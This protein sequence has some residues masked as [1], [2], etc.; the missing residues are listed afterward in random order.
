MSTIARKVL[1]RSTR[2][3]KAIS[4]GRM[5]PGLMRADVLRR[6]GFYGALCGLIVS[7]L[8]YCGSTGRVFAAGP[9]RVGLPW[10]WSHEHLLFSQTD[11]PKVQAI[12]QKDPRAFH[13]WLRRK[14]AAYGVS[15]SSESFAQSDGALF[16]SPSPEANLDPQ[17][18]SGTVKTT[19]KRDWGVSLGA[20][21]FTAVNG[22][23]TPLYPAKYTFNIN[24]VPS[25]IN[26]YAVFPTG[27]QG[28]TS[29]SIVTPNGQAS[30]VAYN[31]LYSTQTGTGT[32]GG[33]G[34]P[35]EN[36][37]PVVYWA[38][39][40]AACPTTASSDPIL[41]SPVISQDGTKVAWV[42]T[43][44]KVQIVA[45]GVGFTLSGPAEGALTPACIGP[46][47]SGGDNATLQTLTLGNATHTP[48]SGVS[49]SEIFVDYSTDSAYVGDDDGYLHKISPFFTASGALQEVTTSGWQASHAYNVGNLIVDTNGFIEKCT[50]AGTSGSVTPGWSN[51]W[52]SA[53]ND[54]TAVWTNIGSGGGWPVYVTGSSGH[55]DSSKLNG[56]VFDS[57]SKNVF[58]GGQ[59]GSLYY[60][61]DPPSSTVV[62]SC[63][64][65]Q[66]LYPCLGLPAAISGITA[67]AGSQTDCYHASPGPTCM[68]M[69]NQQGFTDPV[70]VDS[71]HKLVLAQFA[72]ADG[73]NAKVEQTNTSLGVYHS[74]TLTSTTNS[75]TAYH[76]GAFD[77]T[78]YS[79]P[80]SGYYYVCAPA[81]DGIETDLYRVSFTNTAGTVALGSKNGTPLKLTTNG[82]SGSCAPLTEFYNPNGS[83]VH[84][85]LFVSLDNHG[86][87]TPCA[88]GSC[89]LSFSLASSMV[90]GSQTG[91][92]SGTSGDIANMAGTGGM[93]VDNDAPVTYPQA[94][95][96]YF[97]PV[98]N[99]LTCGDGTS[100]T[101][102][103]VKLTQ[104]GLH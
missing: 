49:V 88:N 82:T 42:T 83:S 29:S 68:I 8:I 35:C 53:T 55:T 103:A 104:A 33:S 97:M 13:Q 69:S 19:E 98:A 25:C 79:T 92:G 102:C 57:V 81:S 62:G 94:S 20:T 56:P 59:N 93:I 31:N 80:A 87:S 27:A 2:G 86:I 12:I 41:S 26:D 45:Y 66:A 24:A 14:G 36:T 39:V 9:E 58:V 37:G 78:Y 48:T 91:Y 21:G 77:N 72:N 63:V 11:D 90:T 17:S 30:I 71:S 23:G 7:A 51:V 75:I 1:P 46:L 52:N 89:V 10:D 3:L 64:N 76:S 54:H 60:V 99:T 15:R 32:E 40:N 100:N 65:G 73:T 70:V 85:W 34:A 61:L 38:Y 22:T 6:L 4:L 74:A 47:M 96:F 101:G 28:K 50:T 5:L 16:E 84:D 43:T 18:A 95:S 44:G 67:A